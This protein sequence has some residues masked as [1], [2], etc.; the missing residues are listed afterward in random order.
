[1]KL[2]KTKKNIKRRK[3]KLKIL[4]FTFF[5][6]FSYVF[7]FFYS[8][9]YKTTK[10]LLYEDINYINLNLYK[11]LNYKMEEKINK[12]VNLLNSNIRVI[13]NNKGIR[14]IKNESATDIVKLNKKEE[15]YNPIVYVYN[16]HQSEKYI[17]YSISDAS[18]ELAN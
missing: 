11:F 6:F 5:F 17:D 2:F 3:C 9:E 7:A 16:T 1:M 13:D 10:K 15:T 8:K 12:P 18:L 4:L 14:K